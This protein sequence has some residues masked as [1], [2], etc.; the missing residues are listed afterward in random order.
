MARVPTILKEGDELLLPKTAFNQY[1]L[2]T[3]PNI[4]IK[5]VGCNRPGDFDPK[6]EFTVFDGEKALIT[7]DGISAAVDYLYGRG[8]F[9]QK[10]QPAQEAKAGE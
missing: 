8:K 4:T 3:H 5:Q 9:A 6:G 2:T 7:V 1:T 10:D